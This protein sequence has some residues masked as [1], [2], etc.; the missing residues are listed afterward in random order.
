MAGIFVRSVFCPKHG[1]KGTLYRVGE[2]CLV[3]I[4]GAKLVII[5]SDIFAVNIDGK[6]IISLK[7]LLIL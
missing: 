7:D 3:S 6:K 1:Y 2:S 4:S 5:I